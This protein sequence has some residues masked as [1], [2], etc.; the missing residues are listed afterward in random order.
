MQ[1]L[2]PSGKSRSLLRSLLAVAAI[3]FAAPVAKGQV[4]PKVP[5]QLPTLTSVRAVH[6]LSA[7]EA[8]RALPVRLRAI[9]TYYD[10][11][12]DHRHAAMFI[13]DS[14]AGIFV[15]VPLGA[16][17][18][19]EQP[20]MG[21]EVEVTGVSAPGDFAA[22]VAEPHIRI[23]KR[24]AQFPHAEPVS[25]T[26][27]LSGAKDCRWVEIEGTIQSVYESASNVSILV[28]MTDGTIS[29]TTVKV[30]GT[31]YFALVDARVRLRGVVSPLFNADRQMTG[32]RIF[33]PGLSS[34]TIDDAA[35]AT[36]FSKPPTPVNELSRFTSSALLSHRVHVRGAVTLQ[37]PGS[38]LCLQDA[39]QGI[40]VQSSQTTTVPVGTVVDVLGFL[41][42]NGGYRPTLK[43]AQ[44]RASSTIVPV[45]AAQVTPSQALSGSRDSELIEI[46]GELIGSESATG[47]PTLILSAGNSIYPVLLPPGSK[48]PLLARLRIGSKLR[49]TG[50][51]SVQVD[52][53]MTLRGEGSAVIKSFHVRLRSPAD[54]IILRTPSFWTASRILLLLLLVVAITFA[55]L[56]W[57]IILRRRVEQQTSLIRESEE[58]FRHLAHHDA[59]TGL[60][61]RTLLHDRLQGALERSR[62]FRTSVALLMLDLDEFK[63]INDSLGH[64][65]GDQTLR[66]TA[67]RILSVIRSTD[68]VARMGGDEFVVL[69]S[70][71]NDIAIVEEVARKLVATLSVPIRIGDREVPVS[72][73]VGV[74]AVSNGDTN[75]DALLKS[76]D[77]AMYHAKARGRN[78]FEIFSHEMER[79]ALE[80]MEVQVSL[81]RALELDEFILNYQA[82]VEVET[83]ALLG[84]EALLRWHSRQLGKVMPDVFIPIAESTGLI[85]P[86]GDWVLRQACR[87]LAELQKLLGRTFILSVN[88]SPRQLVDDSLP[89]SVAAA[90]AD[91]G[92]DPSQLWLE[93]TENILLKDSQPTRDALFKIRSTGVCMALD[94]FGIG[95]SSLA[96][97]TRFAVDWIKIDRSLLRNSLTD[98]SSLAVFRAIVAMAHG[99]NLRVV[100]E[101]V[102][103][104]EQF[105]F[106]KA[107]G[108]DTA[109][110]YLLNQPMP[111][112]L[113]PNLIE[114]LQASG[115]LISSMCTASSEQAST[116]RSSAFKSAS[117][118]YEHEAPEPL[119]TALR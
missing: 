60:P 107:E 59:L 4:L 29:A 64:D 10:P 98:R 66:V 43:N 50:I 95:F 105:A 69:L 45:A 34:V 108:C 70:D 23:L 46:E 112:D 27:M 40:C 58:R 2:G 74:H 41:S 93:I 77:A 109:Q 56:C 15:N 83:G 11:F 86:I 31:N 1:A 39:T 102:E 73:S 33:F 119:E 16:A 47:D 101:G 8:K 20:R 55:V 3:L 85:I 19:S 54:L 30:P 38:L 26:Q 21:S 106:L 24:V 6:S 52:S 48:D 36:A 25:L 96:Y 75:A 17:A 28:A 89:C 82:I 63:Q 5:S 37:W 84:F 67:R 87:E 80:K 13:D 78:C 61:T 51:C 22:V 71:V 57:V 110:G 117:T 111:V 76:A 12:I 113:L 32:A 49:L 92:I 68:T 103:S 88:I 44:Y 42:L 91:T 104:T 62:R 99:L 90:L 35:P 114:S 53:Q 81:S 79:A 65:A 14:T 100:A 9:V 18:A 94:D 97:I 118:I 115:T 7:A 116:F 72:A